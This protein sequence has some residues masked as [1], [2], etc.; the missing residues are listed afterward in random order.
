MAQINDWL[1]IDRL[2]GR[3]NSTITLTA[4]YF[5][6]FEDRNV[7]LNVKTKTST[8]SSILNLKQVFPEY[9]PNNQ[10]WY[11]TKDGYSIEPWQ[12]SG[13]DEWT[14]NKIISSTY[15]NGLGIITFANDITMIGD[16]AFQRKSNLVSIY[17]PDSVTEI[18]GTA[19]V[20]C[21]SL[22]TVHLGNGVT[23]LNGF[24]GCTSLTEITIP[25]GVT[26]LDGFSDCTSLTSITIPDSVT[27][28]GAGAFFR[29]SKLTNVSLGSGIT[30]LSQ[31]MFGYCTSLVSITIPDSVTEIDR[32]AFQGCESLVSITIPDSVTKIDISS[33]SYCTSLTSIIIG[34][35]VTSII[36]GAFYN[37][38]NLNSIT[39]KGTIAPDLDDYYPVFK[40]IKDGGTLYYPSGSDYSEWLAYGNLGK[41]NW[42]GVPY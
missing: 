15:R 31:S 33:F 3:G 5:N 1:T 32:M 26:Y 7:S 24:D 39:C 12:G 29:C 2:N 6:A 14:K 16:T 27:E 4:K 36:E 17:I 21:T 13:E 38:T 25:D 30:V 37:C 20:N 42:T 10:I 28:I 9:P 11:K 41:F 22:T 23:S 35:G 18:H 8:K 19:F 40:N 34:S